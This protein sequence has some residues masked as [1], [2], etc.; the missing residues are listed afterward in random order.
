MNR[1]LNIDT[2]TERAF[3]ALG[4]DNTISSSIYNDTQKDHAAF[5]QKAIEKVCLEDNTSL[6]L[7]DA[8]AVTGGPGSYTGLRVGLASA[9]GLCYA[10]NKPLIMLN[11]LKV[12]AASAIISEPGSESL[13]CPLIDARRM[14]VFTALY[15]K[16]LEIVMPATAMVL[17]SESFDAVFEENEI[18]FFGSGSTKWK[19]ICS[20]EKAKF[21]V[22]NLLPE[23]MNSLS[24]EAFSGANFAETAYSEP[25]YLKEFQTVTHSKS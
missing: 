25:F 22:V 19:S 11:T 23:A 3:V 1:I 17:E 2:S 20:S 16:Q 10:L 15:N 21:S 24:M 9:K 6:N 12:M 13:L 7:I 18:L 5:I 14:E 8:V 4:L